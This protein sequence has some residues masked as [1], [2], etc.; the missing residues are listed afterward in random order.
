MTYF[1]NYAKGGSQVQNKV[2]FKLIIFK[3]ARRAEV[4]ATFQP[5]SDEL[6]VKTAGRAEVRSEIH[7]N[8]DD[9]FLKLPKGRKS[10]LNFSQAQMNYLSRPPEGTPAGVK[11]EFQS[12]SYDLFIKDANFPSCAAQSLVNF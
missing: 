3:T 8:S 1:K 11:S 5:S 6:Y 4:K 7:S 9:L 10:R 12:S 2:K